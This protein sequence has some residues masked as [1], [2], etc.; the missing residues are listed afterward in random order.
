[1]RHMMPVLAAVGLGW[2][3]GCGG[4]PEYRPPPLGG[5]VL[6]QDGSEP[7]ELE[8]GTIEFEANGKVA[9]SAGVRPDGTFL[10]EAALPPGPYRVRV[11]APAERP[12]ALD[13][14]YERFESSGLTHT[15]TADPQQVTFKVR[16]GR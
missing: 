8:G 4:P 16:R 5:V 14:R 3:A 13:P 9:A 10:L 7:R 12:R 11:T 15:A 6:W 1:V 2:A